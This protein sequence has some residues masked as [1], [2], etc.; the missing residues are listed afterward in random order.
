MLMNADEKTIETLKNIA[1]NLSQEQLEIISEHIRS[2]MARNS[3]KN[4]SAQH[5]FWVP[6][7]NLSVPDCPRCGAKHA[8]GYIIKRGRKANGAQRFGC[9]SC[10]RTFTPR[11]GT[12]FAR[13]RKSADA[14]EKFIQ[15]TISGASL[16][17]CMRHCDIAY[18]TAF[19][20][21]HK[22][23]AVFEENQKATKMTGTIEADEMLIPISYKGNHVQG[24][25][26]ARKKTP[27]AVNDMPRKAYKRGTD[28]LSRSSKDKACVFCMVQDGNK[29]FYAAVPG[30]GFMN[31]ITLDATVGK[32]VD[33]EHA[34]ML[35]DDYRVT[36]GYLEKNGYQYTILKSNVSGNP[37]D[38]KP[39][40]KDGL[41][42]QHANA[43]HMHIRRF[44]R[45]YCGVSSKYLSHYIALYVW[46]KSVGTIRNRKS[47]DEISVKRAAMPDCYISRNQIYSRPAIPQCA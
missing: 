21:R 39:E 18:K 5:D 15:L 42:I 14:W 35:A 6:A 17:H 4:G 34:V 32:H 36:R 24:E 3:S 7:E 9:K 47:T 37:K 12:A 28:N 11:T 45:P 44:L 20:W 46:L 43:M 13:A 33:K 27:D 41:H 26:G 29:A 1:S 16:H 22:L 8:L 30:V 23:L 38:H 40:V 31:E 10:N 2:L 19:E 25:F